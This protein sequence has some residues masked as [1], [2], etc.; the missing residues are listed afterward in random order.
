MKFRYALLS[1][2]ALLATP[3]RAATTLDF[4]GAICTVGDFSC[5]NYSAIRQDYGDGVGVDV[6]YRSIIESTGDT[7]EAFLKY[8]Q[9]DY[10]DLTDI[11]WGGLG[12]TGYIAE[13]TFRALPGYEISLIGFDIATYS[14]RTASTPVSITALD[15]TVIFAGSVETN[16]PTHNNVAIDSAYFEEGIVLRW[17]PDAFNTGL[18][19]ISFDVRAVP[20]PASWAMMIAGFGL[21]GGALRRRSAGEAEIATARC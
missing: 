7:D 20:E 19:N 10:G 11:V 3:A 21:I 4:S 18:D 8:W 9:D 17:G 16:I 13:L 5:T 14:Q 15:G 6:S 1:L 12:G 2:L